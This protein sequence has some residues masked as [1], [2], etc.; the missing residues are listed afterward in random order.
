M[1]GD[2]TAISLAEKEGFKLFK[3]VGCINCHNGSIFSDYKMYVL[4]VPENDKLHAIDDGFKQQFSLEHL[5]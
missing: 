3:K 4:S 1:R 2:S 5:L